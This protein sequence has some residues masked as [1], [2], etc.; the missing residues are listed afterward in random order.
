M[1]SA[2]TTAGTTAPP[3]AETSYAK[4]PDPTV[5][6]IEARTG[7]FAVATSSVSDYASGS[8]FGS[9]NITYPTTTTAGGSCGDRNDT[10]R[11]EMTATIR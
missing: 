6:S 8:G 11:P 10:G 1:S 2:A 4:G 7:T 3:P 9:A 5:A